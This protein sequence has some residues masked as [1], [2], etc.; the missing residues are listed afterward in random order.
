MN[1]FRA[2]WHG[3]HASNGFQ[4]ALTRLIMRERKHAMRLWTWLL[5]TRSRTQS[6]RRRCT[7]TDTVRPGKDWLRTGSIRVHEQ[8]ALSAEARRPTQIEYREMDA[9]VVSPVQGQPS[10]SP[11]LRPGLQPRE[12]LAAAGAAP[13]GEALEL[14][15][16]AGEADQDRGESR[17]PC[18]GRHVLVGRGGGAALVVH[19]DS[20]TDRSIAGNSWYGLSD[21]GC[22]KR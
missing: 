7:V 6:F 9:A 2:E 17:E 1:G 21:E 5:A 8:K 3:N 13:G 11:A 12:L 18:E 15:D 4:Q 20:G 10:V 14:D 19:G 22:L 16:T